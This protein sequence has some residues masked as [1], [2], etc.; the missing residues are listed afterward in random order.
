MKRET[1]LRI[2]SGI[3]LTAIIPAATLI[4]SNSAYGKSGSPESAP[5]AASTLH[6]TNW[7]AQQDSVF[8]DVDEMPEFPGGENGLLKYIAENTR[9]P[10]EAKKNNITG[11]VLIR[12]IVRKDCTVAGVTLMNGVSPA[13]DTE[14]VRVIKSLPKFE[15]PGKKDGKTVS[16]YFMV[17][18]TFALK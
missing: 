5:A 15:K 8:T 10:E 3:I 2:L 17:P 16:V 7:Q 1:Q 6:Q 13:I 9:Y 14:A 12:F 4:F 18:I 11:K